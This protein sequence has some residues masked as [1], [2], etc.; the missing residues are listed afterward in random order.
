MGRL[1]TLTVIALAAASLFGGACRVNSAVGSLPPDAS[2]P[3]GSGGQQS[4]SG[5]AL[6]TGGVSGTG[7]SPAAGGAAGAPAGQGGAGTGGGAGAGVAAAVW[8]ATIDVGT[9]LSQN[10]QNGSPVSA[11]S[12]NGDAFI[13]Y[14]GL[15][16]GL[17]VSR[18]VAAESAFDA[19][20]LLDAKARGS[21]GVGVD[22]AGNAIAAYVDGSQNVDARHF[23]T[24][25][26][27]SWGAV[28]MLAS[29]GAQGQMF[30]ES[31]AV[32]PSGHAVASGVYATMS[33]SIISRSFVKVFEAGRGWTT[34][35]N[36]F[37][38]LTPDTLLA[39]ISEV[40]STLK[41]A[42]AA[43]AMDPTQPGNVT[44]VYGHS[45]TYDLGTH[46]GT[47]GTTLTV[48]PSVDN[49]NPY[50][51]SI[52]SDGTGSAWLVVNELDGGGV[53]SQHLARFTNGAWSTTTPVGDPPVGRGTNVAVA[54]SGDALEAWL[55]CAV[56]ADPV[57]GNPTGCAIVAR[58]Y[59]GGAWQ[60]TVPVTPGNLGQSNAPFAAVDG[61]G[62]AVILW[63][64]Y[65]AG[66]TSLFASELDPV[67]GWSTPHSLET[68]TDGSTNITDLSVGFGP[69]GTCL[70]TWATSSTSAS[71]DLVSVVRAAFCHFNT[72]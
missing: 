15:D 31:F 25:G 8:D 50:L 1:S 48:D 52:A 36:L 41:V 66:G 6:A 62:H 22:D 7:G 39:G 13:A 10:P 61:Q 17:S 2:F 67:A 33:G 35:Q 51:S 19:P 14:L 38:G 9:P 60:A 4:G 47:A 5:G 16:G 58:G 34:A 56:T 55:Q 11:M 46:S 27:G 71:G 45:F 20:F 42:L 69:D 54:R 18:Y 40:G 70:A 57:T 68:H 44:Q 29:A 43:E 37:P 65:D 28:E 63:Y 32:T 64:L 3:F 72:P 26:G 30:F 53:M 12:R 21:S 59:V 24:S 49:N 23:S